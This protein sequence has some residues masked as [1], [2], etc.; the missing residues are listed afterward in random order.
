MRC[1]SCG[2]SL[3]NQPAPTDGSPR[4]CPECGVE[5]ALDQFSFA[6]GKVEFCCPACSQTYFGTDEQGHLDPREFD[7][8]TC[9]TP[10][11]MNSCTARPFGDVPEAHAMRV[12]P[13]P[14][15]GGVG[16]VFGRWMRTIGACVS[17]P[18]SIPARIEG[19]GDSG[20]AAR[21]LVLQIAVIS[22]VSLLYA[23]VTVVFMIGVM[24]GVGGGAGPGG[25]APIA[26]APGIGMMMAASA[27]G[28]ALH[29][30]LLLGGIVGAAGFVALV[31][32]RERVGF[33]RMFAVLAFASSVMIFSLVP[34]CGGLL[35]PILWIVQS[36]QAVAAAM[37]QDRKAVAVIVTV[38]I[39]VFSWLLQCG[40]GAISG[41]LF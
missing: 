5:Y 32:G 4:R 2:Y 22:G 23:A 11:T 7:C 39:L 41:L 3:W 34:I 10:L 37:P 29:A 13:L 33:T 16:S 8:V 9:G 12:E 15:L 25:F 30:L 24:G 18:G 21:F 28:V 14:W 38:V 36:A 26:V 6:H 17:D 19:L 35:A 20:A 31:A 1:T 40:A 27:A